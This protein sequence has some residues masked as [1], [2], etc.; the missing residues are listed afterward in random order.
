MAGKKLADQN[1]N[2]VPGKGVTVA[3]P[4]EKGEQDKSA[5]NKTPPPTARKAGLNKGL[6]S[7]AGPSS[8]SL[9]SGG[10][11]TTQTMKTAESSESSSSSSSESEEETTLTTVKATPS[12]PSKYMA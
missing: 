8:Q 12:K 1:A 4:Q 9:I 11:K 3:A 7:K 10:Q 2:S 5:S 6:S